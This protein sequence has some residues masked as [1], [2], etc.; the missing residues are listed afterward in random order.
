MNG[1]GLQVVSP[2]FKHRPAVIFLAAMNHSTA[3]WA[4]QIKTVQEN[5]AP[6]SFEMLSWL[7]FFSWPSCI[8]SSPNPRTGCPSINCNL[9]LSV[10][11]QQKP[12]LRN[13]I[14]NSKLGFHIGF[15]FQALYS[16]DVHIWYETENQGQ[17]GIQ[18]EWVIWQ[19]S[20]ENSRGRAR[21]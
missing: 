21:A 8:C 3:L 12:W 19:V 14:D 11:P 4:D 9:S 17:K 7:W 2:K 6:G 18:K 15:L 16:D 1:Y 10:L 20:H 5:L 13:L